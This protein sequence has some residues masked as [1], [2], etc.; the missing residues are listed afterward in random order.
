[1]N[2]SPQIIARAPA[3]RQEREN[4]LGLLISLIK[5]TPKADQ[6]KHMRKFRH[7]LMSPGYEEFLDAVVD[8]WLRIK[9]STAL[10]AA[11]PP[12]VSELK[13]RAAARKAAV[14]QERAAV[15]AAKA[16]IGE[17]MFVMVMPNGKPLHDCTGAECVT[18]GGH[19]TKIGKAV[20]PRARVGKVMTAASITALLQAK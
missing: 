15:E 18:F 9:F 6:A 8:E 10:R 14:I 3:Q 4:P 19:F 20:G 5:D 17:R 12:S 1:M 2:A 11:T 16:L 13:E 7:L